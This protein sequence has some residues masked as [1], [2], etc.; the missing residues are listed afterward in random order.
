MARLR[1]T[2]PYD[3]RTDQI[4][5]AGWLGAVGRSAIQ[6]FTD[7]DELLHTLSDAIASFWAPGLAARET[8]RRVIVAQIMYTGV[9]ALSLVSIIAFLLGA[10]VIIQTNLMAPADGELLGKVLVAVVLRELAPLITAIVVAGRSGTAM[11]TELG[12]MKVNSEVLA[13]SSLGID[14]PRYIVLP[15]LVASVVSVLVL[16]IYF[17]VVAMFGAFT[18]ARL[19]AD[20]TWGS[21]YSGISRGVMPF[22]LALFLLKGS[23]LGMLVGWLCCHYGLQV[24]S[25]PTEVPQKASRA[26][27][28]SLLTGV[29]YSTFVTAIFYWFVGPPMH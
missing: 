10:S 18:L 23:G 28:M 22:D 6:W 13:L 5:D 26:V 7:V 21:L 20:A 8:V 17:S 29:V 24:R 15:R 25:S 9:Q 27:V 12:N 19:T 4:G 16:M 1:S 14:P 3:P 11:A 2:L